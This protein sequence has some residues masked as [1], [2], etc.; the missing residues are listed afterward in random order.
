[1]KHSSRLFHAVVLAGF[2]LSGGGLPACSSDVGQPRGELA[3]AAEEDGGATH[4]AAPPL[5]PDAGWAPT[6]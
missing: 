6:K 3:D 2:S 1:M 5:Q 4:D